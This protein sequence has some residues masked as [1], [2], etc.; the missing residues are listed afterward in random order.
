MFQTN[1][2]MNF[3]V[4][5]FIYLGQYAE[6]AKDADRALIDLEYRFW[7]DEPWGNIVYTSTT[8]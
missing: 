4:S 7:T 8:Q 5:E 1:S 6:G 3:S 2:G